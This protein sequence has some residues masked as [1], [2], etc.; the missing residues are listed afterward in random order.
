[1]V[2]FIEESAVQQLSERAKSALQESLEELSINNEEIE[3]IY[4]EDGLEGI[5]ELLE[6]E[7]SDFEKLV[8]EFENNTNLVPL[9][10]LVQTSR[11][12]VVKTREQKISRLAQKAALEIAKDKKDPLYTKYKKFRRLEIAL[13]K[14]LEEKYSNRARM[15][16]MKIAS[17]TDSVKTRKSKDI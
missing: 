2:L 7:E 9:Q 14:K 12:V 15:E 13:R 17:S 6:K 16:A 10:E 8:E 5:E 3:I 1:M 11:R 4:E